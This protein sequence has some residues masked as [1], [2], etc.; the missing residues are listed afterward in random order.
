MV[1][2]LGPSERAGYR[3]A[4]N[5]D[6]AHPI[7]NQAVGR[8]DVAVAVPGLNHYLATAHFLQPLRGLIDPEK[9]AG[10][11]LLFEARLGGADVAVESLDGFRFQG[12]AGSRKAGQQGKGY[13]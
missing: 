8:L 5:E 4:R 11:A 6:G 3:R 13:S 10:A 9:R 7:V 1:V 12:G 2:I